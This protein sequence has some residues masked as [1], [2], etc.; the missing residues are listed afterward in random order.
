M[1][2]LF[3]SFESFVLAAFR[4]FCQEKN[5]IKKKK[6]K[7]RILLTANSKPTILFFAILA[8]IECD[9]DK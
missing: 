2:T 6:K 5:L 8:L 3:K 4:L 7:K 1:F 9:L